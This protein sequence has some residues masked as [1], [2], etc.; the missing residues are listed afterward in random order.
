MGIEYFHYLIPRPNDF[1][2]SARHIVK[3]VDGL[4]ESSWI[5][6]PASPE[7]AQMQFQTY[8]Y[9][10]HARSTG[11][12][13]G[14]PDRYC[15]VPY[16]TTED[17]LSNRLGDDLILCWP[18]NH[19]GNSGLHYPFADA[20]GE[21]PDAYFDL[22]LEFSPNYV[23]RAAESLD[24]PSP[25]I[26]CKRCSKKLEFWAEAP[27]RKDIFYSMRIHPKCPN[28]GKRFDVSSLPQI[29]RDAWTGEERISLGGATSRFALAID[30]GKCLPKARG[31]HLDP[32]LVAF[33]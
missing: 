19:F 10:V 29:N 13:A 20:R 6:N 25:P 21:E 15:E 32:S 30:C 8:D 1:F 9:H 28:C 26:K 18:V 31:I 22:R 12:F 27:S 4:R 16:P 5:C 11:A 24:P 33:A 23:C 14:T 7:F 3:L 2:P 17:W